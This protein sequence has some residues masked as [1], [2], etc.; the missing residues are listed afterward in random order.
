MNAMT[1][2]FGDAI[3][4]YSRKQALEDGV[5]VDLSTN[6]PETTSLYKY[7]V[8]CTAE[9]WSELLA[10]KTRTVDPGVIWDLVW[11]SRSNVVSRLDPTTILFDVL[12]RGRKRR[13]KVV[14]GPNDDASPCLTIMQEGQD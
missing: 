4:T 3:Y 7:P 9:V 8:A 5:L 2:L 10:P 11:M 13:Y 14:C 6:Y 1:E 12:V